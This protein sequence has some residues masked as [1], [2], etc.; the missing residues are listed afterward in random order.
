VLVAAL[1]V[2]QAGERPARRLAA[3]QFDLAQRP[4]DALQELQPAGLD[5][6]FGAVEVDY[7]PSSWQR[8]TRV[9][10]TYLE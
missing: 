1:Q 9:V 3:D 4:A 5:H 7:N 8:R 2:G 10:D 6:L